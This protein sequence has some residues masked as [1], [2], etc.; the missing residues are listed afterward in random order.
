MKT[1]MMT[2]TSQK[3]RSQS[4][5]ESEDV[6]EERTD[7]NEHLNCRWRHSQKN[8]DEQ[9]VDE[10]PSLADATADPTHTPSMQWHQAIAIQEPNDT[11]R[12]DGHS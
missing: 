2:T 11:D 6:F 5:L 12:P 3:S 7:L 1:T 4:T 8:H 10:D 9:E